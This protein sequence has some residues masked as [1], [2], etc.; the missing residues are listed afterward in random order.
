MSNAANIPLTSSGPVARAPVTLLRMK[1]CLVPL[2]L[3]LLVLTG[4]ARHYRI[5]LN[6]NHIISTTSKPKLNKRGDAFV[7]KDGL[8][9]PMALPAGVVKQIEPQ[10]RKPMEDP[11]FKPSK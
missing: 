11:I 4:C 3:S 6:N 1:K 10:S 8:G 5:T 2:C 9:K 7:F